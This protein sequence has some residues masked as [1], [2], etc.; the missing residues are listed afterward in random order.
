MCVFMQNV[1]GLPDILL[2]QIKNIIQSIEFFK[3][4]DQVG[5]FT[6]KAVSEN[7]SGKM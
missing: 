6:R 3:M 7:P 5:E 1:E 2:Q 4:S